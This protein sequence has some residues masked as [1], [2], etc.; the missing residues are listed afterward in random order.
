MSV[1]REMPHKGIVLNGVK[2]QNARKAMMQLQENITFLS[3]RVV[4]LQKELNRTQV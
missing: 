1:I 2:D 4:E 3:A